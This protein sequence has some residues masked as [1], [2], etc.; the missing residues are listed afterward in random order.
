MEKTDYKITKLANSFYVLNEYKLPSGELASDVLF[1]TT[2][3]RK[4]KNFLSKVLE[5]S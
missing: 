2:S 5:Q 1:R 3:E 4:A